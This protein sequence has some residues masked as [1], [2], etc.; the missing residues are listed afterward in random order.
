MSAFPRQDAVYTLLVQ[1]HWLWIVVNIGLLTSA[2]G[3]TQ[4]QASAVSTFLYSGGGIC[5]VDPLG[6]RG[7]TYIS[8]FPVCEWKCFSLVYGRCGKGC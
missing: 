7:H 4:R 1:E 8:S 6:K 3:G 2:Q 5:G